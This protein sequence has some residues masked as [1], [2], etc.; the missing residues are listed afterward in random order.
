M[1]ETKPYKRVTLEGDGTGK[2][3]VQIDNDVI[4]REMTF[5]QA[6]KLIEMVEN[7]EWDGKH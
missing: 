3:R 1:S 4:G 2:F 5:Q 7:G 6:I